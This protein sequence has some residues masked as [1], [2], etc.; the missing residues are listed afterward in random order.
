MRASP[1]S[2]RRCSPS[3]AKEVDATNNFSGFVWLF[4]RT[5]ITEVA[6]LVGRSD[7]AGSQDYINVRVMLAN[8]AGNTETVHLAAQ[9]HLRKDHVD[10]LPGTKYGHNVSS[11]DALENLVAAVA[12]I[13]SDD[14]PDKD[15]GLDDQNRA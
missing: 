13:A 12:Q 15:V 11:C 2:P 14:H 6:R 1:S 7:G 4:E 8:P 10:L 9:P 3:F 5:I